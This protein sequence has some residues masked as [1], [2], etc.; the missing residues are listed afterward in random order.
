MLSTRYYSSL[1]NLLVSILLM[2]DVMQKNYTDMIEKFIQREIICG[3]S[4]KVS[5]LSYTRLILV[6][7]MY[8]IS[9]FSKNSFWDKNIMY[10]CW[11]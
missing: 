9:T 11:P 6:P 1:S 10:G 4:Q 5:D 8:H 2:V 7:L 3:N